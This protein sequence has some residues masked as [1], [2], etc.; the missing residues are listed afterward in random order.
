MEGVEVVGDMEAED[1]E[2]V[3]QQEDVEV[4]SLP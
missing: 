3:A 4:S 2:V 1:E